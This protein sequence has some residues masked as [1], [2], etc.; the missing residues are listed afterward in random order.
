MGLWIGVVQVRGKVPLTCGDACV[1]RTHLRVQGGIAE[2]G[3]ARATN[4]LLAGGGDR[5]VW[6]AGLFALGRF[7][8]RAGLT[9]ALSAAVPTTR[10][11]RPGSC[12]GAVLAY[13]LWVPA[14]DGGRAADRLPGYHWPA[15]VARS[16]TQHS[17]R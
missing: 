2:V 5:V 11:A 9:E 12:R 6:G 3:A 14:G 8:D 13:V 10:G 1:Q 7:A 16:R 4:A 17:L 15:N